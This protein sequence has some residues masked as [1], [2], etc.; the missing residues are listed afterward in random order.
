[1]VSAVGRGIAFVLTQAVEVGSS[2]I[3]TFI[4]AASAASD[5]GLVRSDVL[6]R[7]VAQGTARIEASPRR[8]AEAR[9]Q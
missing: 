9:K 3:V 2:P 8:N 1:V 6:A 7:A 4:D 5:G